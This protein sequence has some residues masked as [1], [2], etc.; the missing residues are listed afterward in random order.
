MYC[1]VLYMYCLDKHDKDV[2]RRDINKYIINI[3][4]CQNVMILQILYF[5][6][7]TF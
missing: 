1:I 4:W 7:L 2:R 3:T 6:N 5:E